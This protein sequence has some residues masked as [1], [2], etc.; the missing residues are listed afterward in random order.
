MWYRTSQAEFFRNPPEVKR[1]WMSCLSCDWRL[2]RRHYSGIIIEIKTKWTL[3]RSLFGMFIRGSHRV[4]TRR[5]DEF[6][7]ISMNFNEFRCHS[8]ST[9][10]D[11]DTLEIFK[12]FN[13]KLSSLF[14]R[15][16]K[17]SNQESLDQVSWDSCIN[18]V[19]QDSWFKK[20][21]LG[22]STFPAA[23][24]HRLSSV[25]KIRTLNFKAQTSFKWL[26][27]LR[28]TSK[29]SNRSSLHSNFERFKT[30]KNQQSRSLGNCIAQLGHKSPM[31][32]A[33]SFL[34]NKKLIWCYKLISVWF[35]LFRPFRTPTGFVFC[36]C[37]SKSPKWVTKVSMLLGPC[38]STKLTDRWIECWEFG[39]LYRANN[40][41]LSTLWQPTSCCSRLRETLRESE[42]Q[43]KNDRKVKVE[44]CLVGFLIRNALECRSKE[45]V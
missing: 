35:C 16:S 1:C 7:W 27:D 40:S 23:N 9:I 12:V 3:Q 31:L 34:I 11:L 17:H 30:M 22:V 2:D 14:D 36:Y 29:V 45:S 38:Y 15:L 20:N 26:W 32:W 5:V 37:Q 33:S 13:F 4:R 10:A 44:R 41:D 28:S 25:Q 19:D 6:R 42:Q 18:S 21:L 8:A 39:T 43:S 24:P